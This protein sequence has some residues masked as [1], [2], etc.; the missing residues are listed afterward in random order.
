MDRIGLGRVWAAYLIRGLKKGNDIE[1]GPNLIK[2][3]EL[4]YRSKKKWR[5][6]VLR[7]HNSFS[8]SRQLMTD[9]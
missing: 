4:L 2:E 1:N 7:P 5:R 6:N 8:L 3:G 9:S